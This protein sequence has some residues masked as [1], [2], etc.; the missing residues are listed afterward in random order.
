MRAALTMVHS[1]WIV[2]DGISVEEVLKHRR[3][4]ND[5]ARR[6]WT[7]RVSD[8]WMIDRVGDHVRTHI[9]CRLALLSE[10]PAGVANAALGQTRV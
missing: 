2:E 5:G 1:G 8:A 7:G 6:Q 10:P 4:C 9:T 3:D